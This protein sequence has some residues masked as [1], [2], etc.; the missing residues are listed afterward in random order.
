MYMFINRLLEKK[1]FVIK[2]QKRATNDAEGNFLPFQSKCAMNP[3][4]SSFNIFVVPFI[5]PGYTKLLLL[6]QQDKTPAQA[7]CNN[8]LVGKVYCSYFSRPKAVA[9]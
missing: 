5:L 6:L 8:S 2:L 3:L 9:K 7:I 1:S 4:I